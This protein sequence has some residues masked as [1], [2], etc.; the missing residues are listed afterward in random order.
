MGQE[1]TKPAASVQTT[2]T[3]ELNEHNAESMLMASFAESDDS[4]PATDGNDDTTQQ[5]S[6]VS[7]GNDEDSS[8]PQDE[9]KEDDNP[10]GDDT[11]DSKNE[12]DD[13]PF[14]KSAKGWQKR[15]NKLTAQKKAKD[16]EIELLKREIQELKSGR[17]QPQQQTKSAKNPVDDIND[18]DK[19]DEFTTRTRVE[20]DKVLEM[21]SSDAPDFEIGNEIYTREQ[22]LGYLKILNS[23]LDEAIPARRK[24]LSHAAMLQQ[25]SKENDAL[26]AKN[27]PDF[28]EG[29][30][31]DEWIKEQLSDQ[32]FEANKK[33][34]LHYAWKGLTLSQVEAKYKGKSATTSTKKVLPPAP[35]SSASSPRISASNVVSKDGSLNRDFA[36]KLLFQ[37]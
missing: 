35:A 25:K 15:V 20:R 4:Q 36:A 11:H 7:N 28:K 1:E 9:T 17:S 27:F 34:L 6:D 26:I 14:V 21:L 16:D 23:D 24:S 37:D 18:L 10:N 2:T 8:A 22:I 29:S 30:A 13:D 19:L 12:T 33:I 32:F 31:E 3:D 5:T